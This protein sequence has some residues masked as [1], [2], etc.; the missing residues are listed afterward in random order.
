MPRYMPNVIFTAPLLPYL[1]NIYICFVK[2][3]CYRLCIMWLMFDDNALENSWICRIFICVWGLAQSFLSCNHDNHVWGS[4]KVMFCWFSWS[5]EIPNDNQGL[6]LTK[7]N[8]HGIYEVLLNCRGLKI[9]DFLWNSPI[10][11][12]SYSGALRQQSPCKHDLKFPYK[13]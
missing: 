5:V 10:R 7:D 13:S 9:S 6:L 4:G 11:P 8:I 3:I 1:W 12:H 2:Y